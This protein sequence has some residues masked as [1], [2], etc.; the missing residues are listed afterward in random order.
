M[1]FEELMSQACQSAN[2]PEM[3]RRQLPS[4]LKPET[5]RLVMKLTSDEFGKRLVR[6]IDRVNHGSVDS[7][8]KLVNEEL[9]TR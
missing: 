7:I 5:K 2:L 4:A 3:A 6:A 1:T 9:L 8:D